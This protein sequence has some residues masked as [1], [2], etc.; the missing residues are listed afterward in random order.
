MVTLDQKQIEALLKLIKRKKDRKAVKKLFQELEND[1]GES[2]GDESKKRGLVKKLIDLIIKG[3]VKIGEHKLI[4]EI[5]H[6][7]D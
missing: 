3:G 7:F 2:P 5:L 1:P 4:E 6:V